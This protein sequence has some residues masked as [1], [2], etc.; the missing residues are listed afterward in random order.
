MP[1][2]RERAGRVPGRPQARIGSWVPRINRAEDSVPKASIPYATL[3]IH[4]D[5][6]NAGISCGQR[7]LD[8]LFPVRIESNNVV[9]DRVREPDVPSPEVNR[10]SVWRSVLCRRLIELHLPG[11][12]IKFSEL[13]AKV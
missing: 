7:V 13:V 12:R 9:P 11:L 5:E 1:A 10:H 2:L 6:S 4:S 8:E 3:R